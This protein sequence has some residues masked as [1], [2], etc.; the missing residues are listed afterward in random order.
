MIISQQRRNN[1]L[2]GQETPDAET[3]EMLDGMGGNLQ[4]V[5]KIKLVARQR[6][7]H[8]SLRQLALNIINAYKTESHAHI[9][10]ARAIGT[11][12]QEHLDYVR[13][14]TDIEQLHDPLMY[15]DQLNRGVARGDCDDMA[16]LVA[17]LLLC[18][19]ARPYVRC[20]RYGSNNSRDNYNHIYV[21]VYDTN[22]PFGK[23]ERLAIDCII[24]DQ[25]IGFE[26]NH[27]SGDEYEI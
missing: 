22:K 11:F 16:C 21:V 3:I 10:E 1:F 9:D 23:S 25:P 4:T 15:I 18:I 27:S 2:T 7:G 19:G 26:L 13:D 14:A 12:V 5:E 6:S 20:V 8:P 17:T 24:K